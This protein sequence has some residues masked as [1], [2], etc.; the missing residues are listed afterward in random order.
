MTIRS[1]DPAAPAQSLSVRAR[2]MIG[3][4][5][6][7]AGRG[8]ATAPVEAERSEIPWLKAARDGERSEA[9]ASLPVSHSRRLSSVLLA[10]PAPTP[11]LPGPP[12]AV[13]SRG[14]PPRRRPPRSE[15]AYGPLGER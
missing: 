12:W 13:R 2:R 6:P 5:D 10:D 4:I 8:G 9:A 3:S 11:L 14:T 15:E 1:L 7:G